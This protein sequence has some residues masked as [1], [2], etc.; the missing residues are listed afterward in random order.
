VVPFSIMTDETCKMDPRIR[1]TR[2]MLFLAFQ[3]LLTEKTFDQISVQ[4]L[5]ERSTL[6]RATFY[7]HFPDKFA[8]LEAMI[9][10]RFRTFI[11]A[12]LVGK[13]D[14]C[15]ASLKLLILAACDFLAEV[16]SGCQK[17]QRQFEPI[18]ESRVKAVMRESLLEGLRGHQA[19]SPELKATMVSWAITGAALH[20]SRERKMSADELAEA[21]LP[22]V[23]I[24]LKTGE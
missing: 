9:S 19:K 14:T 1:R 13:V 24:A 2:Q 3:E 21:V 8:L 23:H 11:E 17:H 6:N 22:T 20:W 16:S 18:V 7:D 5:A 15:E 10:E 12:R 4:D